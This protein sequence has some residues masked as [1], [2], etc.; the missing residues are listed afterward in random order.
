MVIAQG[1]ILTNAHNLRG[2]QV[3]VTF[4]DGRQDRGE[5]L[6]AD[7]DGDVAVIAVDTGSA[8]ALEWA[9]GVLE[10]GSVAFTVSRGAGGVTRTTWGTVSAT[11]RAFRGP[12]G[13]RID[14]SLEH[15][16]PLP[17]RSSGSPVLDSHGRLAGLNTNRAGDGFYLALPT[18]AELRRR[19]EALASGKVPGARQLGVALAPTHVARKLRRSVGL[20]ERDGLL[21]R[22]VEA[23]MAADRA[24]MSEGDLIV[25]AG[26]RAVVTVDDLYAALDAAGDRL[27]VSVVR[28]TD[29]VALTVSFAEATTDGSST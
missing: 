24:G 9:P 26:D 19:V 10:V 28:G 14:G 12:R 22:S 6:G 20:P 11:E 5:V 3:T 1:Q 4:A 18:D 7:L 17:S 23:G 21:V 8:P 16:A 2:P 25:S 29:E 27:E 15:T 13:R